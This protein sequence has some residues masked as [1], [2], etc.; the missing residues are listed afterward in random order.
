MMG[1]VI[2]ATAAAAAGRVEDRRAHRRL[3]RGTQRSTRCHV[4]MTRPDGVG[5]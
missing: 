1:V 4:P 5:K 2:G 3:G